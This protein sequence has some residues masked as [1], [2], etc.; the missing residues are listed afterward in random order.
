MTQAGEQPVEKL[1]SMAGATVDSLDAQTASTNAEALWSFILNL[2]EVRQREDWAAA[3]LDR[4]EDAAIDLLMKLVMKLNERQFKPLFMRLLSW[5]ADPTVIGLTLM[6]RYNAPGP[7]IS[8]LPELYGE[9]LA[10]AEPLL[11][12]HSTSL[13]ESDQAYLRIL[14]FVTGFQITGEL[15]PAMRSGAGDKAAGRQ[16]IFFKIINALAGGLR[17]VFVPY[18]RHLQ[19][20]M[21]SHLS[22][23]GQKAKGNP[24]KKR[25]VSAA[26]DDHEKLAP[27]RYQVC[28]LWRL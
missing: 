13:P 10:A 12:C 6:Y 22:V 24:K 4:V 21:L 27:I 16:V 23:A 7:G 8:R 1:S 5:A 15:S 17:G 19:S 26:I 18:F 20:T 9:T 25:R 11:M 2:L 14:R 28:K 3:S